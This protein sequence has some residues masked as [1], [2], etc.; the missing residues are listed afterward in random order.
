[1]QLY[2]ILQE[3]YF[4]DCSDDGDVI[5][6]LLKCLYQV[7]SCQMALNYVDETSKNTHFLD[8]GLLVD[9]L[10]TTQ[11]NLKFHSDMTSKM[12]PTLLSQFLALLVLAELPGSAKYL[13]HNNEHLVF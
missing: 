4:V 8:H 7:S 10:P 13:T 6:T 2:I 12:R 5:Y 3:S 9:N 1:M 11:P